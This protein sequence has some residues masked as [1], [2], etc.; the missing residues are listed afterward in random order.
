MKCRTSLAVCAK[1]TR[2][3]IDR[4]GK[5]IYFIDV[6][7]DIQPQLIAKWLYF[8]NKVVTSVIHGNIMACIITASR[9]AQTITQCSGGDMLL[10]YKQ[11]K[12]TATFTARIR[13][14]IYFHIT[15]RNSTND[16]KL[17]ASMYKKH[18]A[19]PLVPTAIYTHIDRGGNS[20]ELQ[21][22]VSSSGIW[23]GKMTAHRLFSKI[24]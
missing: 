7:Y 16:R 8:D 12:V 14:W 5:T 21:G 11:F 19:I 3:L 23:S 4:R 10:S 6:M 13:T 24:W 22:V 1:A 20:I 17:L 9:Y 18:N 2:L 15:R